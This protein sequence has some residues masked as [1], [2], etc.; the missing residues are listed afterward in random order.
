MNTLWSCGYC[1]RRQDSLCSIWSGTALQIL[2]IQAS[3]LLAFCLL[4]TQSSLWKRCASSWPGPMGI[5]SIN[6]QVAGGRAQTCMSANGCLCLPFRSSISSR[7][8][9]INGTESRD[10]TDRD[11]QD[12]RVTHVRNVF[13][14]LLSVVLT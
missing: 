13:I 5:L 6:E 12:K 4:L 10:G 3:G 14:L 2:L 7:S 11:S 1:C 9:I 8:W